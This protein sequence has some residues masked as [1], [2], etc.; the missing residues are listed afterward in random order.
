MSFHK[1]AA[2]DTFKNFKEVLEYLLIRGLQLF[3]KFIFSKFKYSRVVTMA[4]NLGSS[5]NSYF[6]AVY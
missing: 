6:T 1:R 2:D 5:D 3:S 4:H